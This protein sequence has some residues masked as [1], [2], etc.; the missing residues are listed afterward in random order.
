MV[1][2]GR[3]EVD[4]VVSDRVDAPSNGDNQSKSVERASQSLVVGVSSDGTSLT[5]RYEEET[6]LYLFT[7]HAGI[8]I[9]VRE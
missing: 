6:N 7:R 3:A 8:G 5:A 9:K 4:H 1:R 2:E